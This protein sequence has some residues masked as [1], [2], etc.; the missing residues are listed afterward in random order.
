MECRE[1][2]RTSNYGFSFKGGSPT[3]NIQEWDSRNPSD[4]NRG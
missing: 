4:G 3:K 2:V 1:C